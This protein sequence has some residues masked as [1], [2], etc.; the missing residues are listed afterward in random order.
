MSP[1]KI[2]DVVVV[3]Q[4]EMVKVIKENDILKKAIEVLPNTK[5]KEI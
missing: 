3:K 4:K 5:L 2:T 1:T